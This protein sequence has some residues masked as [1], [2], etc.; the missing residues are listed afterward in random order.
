MENGDDE[1]CRMCGRILDKGM[2]C[3]KC[4]KKLEQWRENGRRNRI[5]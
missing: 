5:D 4:E 2:L 3:D 1:Y